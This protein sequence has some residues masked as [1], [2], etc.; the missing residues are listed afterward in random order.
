MVPDSFDIDVN[1]HPSRTDKPH[2][3]VAMA[4][5]GKFFKSANSGDSERFGNGCNVSIFVHDPGIQNG[6]AFWGP[7]PVADPLDPHIGMIMKKAFL[8]SN[9]L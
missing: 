6:K 4:R 2:S 7:P 9:S 8:Y 5:A 1:D 3:S